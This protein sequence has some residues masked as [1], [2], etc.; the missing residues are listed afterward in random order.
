M[1]D[2]SITCPNGH[3][4][5]AGS[6]FCETCGTALRAAAAA[7]PS[8]ADRPLP[9]QRREE[10][11]SPAQSDPVVTGGV[12][13]RTVVLLAALVG[14][15]A[16]VATGGL[17]FLLAGGDDDAPAE[18][19]A[20]ETA[21]PSPSPGETA[22]PAPPTEVPSPTPTPLPG[23]TREQPLP[24]GVARRGFDGWEVFV[25]RADF[26][27]VQEVMAENPLNEPPAAGNTFVLVRLNATN[28]EVEPDAGEETAEFSP[29]VTYR[30]VDAEGNEFASF[31]EPRCGVIPD[32]FAFLDNPQPRGGAVEGNICFQ[33]PIAIT[34]DVVMFDDASNTW[35]ALR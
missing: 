2:S 20:T 28:R 5:E 29:G 7:A 22:T 24:L 3:Q 33:V 14:I 11:P 16:A 10:P 15:G 17:V 18:A 4:N 23:E 27:V 30:L 25:V 34:S 26:D 8:P 32:G 19:E 6:K 1:S 13:M 12:R 31:D 21:E 35:F 9:A